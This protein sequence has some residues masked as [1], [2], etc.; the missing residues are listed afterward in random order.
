VTG[1]ARR[2]RADEDAGAPASLRV[3]LVITFFASVSGGTFWTGIFFVTAQ[4]YRFSAVRNLALGAA[5][6]AVY[7]LA[8]RFTGPLLRALERHFSPRAILAGALTTW[9]VAA[10]LPLV[11]ADVEPLFWLVALVG[12][13]ASA[14]TWPV[15]EGYLGAGRHGPAM[16]RAIGWFN[17]T[18]T[19][20]TA[21]SLL[22]LPLLGR[23]NVLLTIAA[24]ALV[25][26]IAVAA[27]FGLPARPG[28]HEA[29]AAAAAIGREY[30][31][32]KAAASWLLPLSYLMSATLSPIL[33]HR[34][35]AW[36]A[37]APISV[38][39]ASWMVARFATLLAMWRLGFWHGRWGTLFAAGAALCGGLALV[40]LGTSL[41][42][43][44]AGLLLLGAGTGLTYY[45][46]LYYTL[47][48]GHAAV[49]AGGNFE[50][51][52]GLGYFAGPLIGLCG[53]GLGPLVAGM[54]RGG[55]AGAGGAEGARAATVALTWAA[56]AFFV[57]RAIGPYAKARAR[58]RGDAR[59]MT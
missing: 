50:A 58:R 15:V 7:A 48:V 41:V 53:Q 24:S 59:A 52:I 10:A 29:D 23:A 5:M 45:A 47:A 21:V 18:W 51:L 57:A 20:A 54:V 1:P 36:G 19:C 27:L 46:A 8:A 44:V 35:A 49:D 12:A 25:N 42:Q 11:A 14:I 38:I 32:L 37:V 34:L 6:G 56:A 17:V 9:G 43:V 26:A 40:F 2:A 28:P 39:A 33:P 55:E 30:P 31:A 22:A 4:H 13:A 3:L 16:R